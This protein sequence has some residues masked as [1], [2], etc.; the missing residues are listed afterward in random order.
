MT[1]TITPIK[2]PSHSVHFEIA[3]C[4]IVATFRCHGSVG[5][6]FCRSYCVSCCGDD[7]R[8]GCDEPTHRNDR[9]PLEMC[10][11]VDRT[12]SRAPMRLY[13]GGDHPLHTGFIVPEWNGMD[14]K[15]QYADPGD[16]Y[17]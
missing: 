5:N 1:E 14:W 4:E 3:S 13:K 16:L 15:W 11:F 7:V 8:P 12:Q 9:A 10:L 17:R 2:K 6:P